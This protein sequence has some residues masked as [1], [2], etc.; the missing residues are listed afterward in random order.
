VEKQ[1]LK[2]RLL[3]VGNRAANRYACFACHEI[4]GMENKERIGTEL[5][6][7]E[8]WG[9]KDVDRLDFGL[10]RDPKAVE[11]YAKDWNTGIIPERPEGGRFLPKRKPEWAWLK[12]M[13]PRVYDAGMT[14]QPGEKLVMPNFHFAPAEADAVVTFLLSLQRVEIPASRR[15]IHDSREILAEKKTWIARQYNC[16]GCHTVTRTE[17][18]DADGKHVP[19]AKGGDIRPWL[20]DEK[21][22]WPPSLGGE[23][24]MGE[25]SRVQPAWLFNFLRNP[26]APDGGGR[27]MLRFWMYTRMPTFGFTQQELNGLVQGFAAEDAVP[28]PFEFQQA[29]ELGK[30]AADAKLLFDTL[31]C[32]SCHPTKAAM[33]AGKTPSG[34]APDLGFARDRLRHQWV[35]Q[36]LDNPK[37]ILPGTGMP[38]F[39]RPEKDLVVPE[40]FPGVFGKDPHEQIRKVADYVFGLGK[41]PEGAGTK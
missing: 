10:M 26:A 29:S 17:R 6:G 27:N 23:G 2:E 24:T 1:S 4:K 16:Y 15:R 36:W 14:K 18:V 20:G 35:K 25:G 22:N 7:G 31:N 11:T 12:L 21:A 37:A 40:G 41:P 3:T 38:A 30:D 19:V 28:F 9:S 34:F 13:N 8:G 33:D 5:G 39:W 32:G